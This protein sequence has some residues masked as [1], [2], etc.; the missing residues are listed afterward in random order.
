MRSGWRLVPTAH[1]CE[2]VLL[3]GSRKDLCMAS[4]LC[5]YRGRRTRGGGGARKMS[6]A[7]HRYKSDIYCVLRLLYRV[8]ELPVGGI[9]RQSPSLFVPSPRVGKWLNGTNLQPRMQEATP[10]G[11][12]VTIQCCQSFCFAPTLAITNTIS[13]GRDFGSLLAARMS[14]LVITEIALAL[15][16]QGLYCTLCEPCGK[17][18]PTT[19]PSAGFPCSPSSRL[20]WETFEITKSPLILRSSRRL[21]RSWS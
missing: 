9:F 5:V 14:L 2:R 3:S 4:G 13:R 21:T 7:L 10:A 15:A 11:D 8:I 20:V 16:L 12:P 6:A 19:L 17:A 18:A 1:I